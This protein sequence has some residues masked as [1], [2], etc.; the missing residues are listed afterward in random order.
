MD[1]L[2]RKFGKYAISNLSMILIICYGV[3]YILKYFN[4]GSI[5]KFLTLNP[6]LILHGQ[7]WRLVSWIM[8]PPSDSNVFLVLIMLLFYYSLGTNLERTWGAFR[9]NVYI[10][11]GM[12][13]TV[14]GAFLLYGVYAGLT[15]GYYETIGALIASSF[16]TYYIN[17]SIFLAFAVMYPNMTVMLYFI[18]PIKMKWM[19]I[20]YGAM[21]LL[22]FFQN[23]YGGKVAIVASLLNFIV[24]FFMQKS[25]FK[26]SPRARMQ[27]AKRRHEFNNNLKRETSKITKHKCAICGRTEDDS[28]DLVFRFCS[29]CN[30]N[31]E[32]C[33][34]HLFT[35]KHIE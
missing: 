24:F 32:Y 5:L 26:G 33:N 16:S 12:L 3:G 28:P 1:K 23:G 34:E 13:F 21:I 25:Y 19:A 2:E 14:I 8:I 29:K 17:M 30:G 4:N 35:H 22:S 15:G 7:V 27:Q 6:Y 9:Y 11:S 10:F 18:I 31:Y 20:V